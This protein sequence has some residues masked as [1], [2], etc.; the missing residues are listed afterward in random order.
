M[1][2]RYLPT[3]PGRVLMGFN[4]SSANPGVSLRFDDFND[5][6]DVSDN[7]DIK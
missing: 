1:P 6:N 2:P 7:S 4:A 3:G 5:I